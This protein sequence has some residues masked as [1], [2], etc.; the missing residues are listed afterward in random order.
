MRTMLAAAFLCL[1][2]GCDKT[3]HEARIPGVQPVVVHQEV[4]SVVVTQSR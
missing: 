4:V 1:A 3:I 2:L